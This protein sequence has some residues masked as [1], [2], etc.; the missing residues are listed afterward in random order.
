MVVSYDL[1]EW[2][3]DQ[4]AELWILKVIGYRQGLLSKLRSY[5][6]IG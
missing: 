4:V 3:V 2:L 5:P 1:I 6:P